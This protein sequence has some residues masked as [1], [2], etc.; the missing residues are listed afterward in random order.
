MIFILSQPPLTLVVCFLPVREVTY[1]SVDLVYDIITIVIQ[2]HRLSKFGQETGNELEFTSKLA[3]SLVLPGTAGCQFR[4]E[5]I[6]HWSR[7]IYALIV[8]N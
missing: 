5:S 3:L 2:R 7:Y 6:C 1:T 8:V 4:S